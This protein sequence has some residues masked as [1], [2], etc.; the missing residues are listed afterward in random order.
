MNKPRPSLLYPLWLALALAILPALS[1]QEAPPAQPAPEKTSVE[2]PAPA[3]PGEKSPSPAVEQ[4][5]ATA[6]RDKAETTIEVEETAESEMRELT[7]ASPESGQKPAKSSKKSRRTRSVSVGSGGDRPPFGSHRVPAEATWHEAVSIM[8]STIVDG[9]VSSDAVAV[10]GSTTV[11]GSVGGSAIAVLGEVVVNGTVEGEVVAVLGD[12][13]LGPNAVIRGEI[14]CVLGQVVRSDGAQTLGGVNEIGDFG[15]F[16]GFE[17][18]RAWLFKCLAWGR[19]LAF[20]ENL[21]WAWMVAG[22][23]LVFYVLLALLFPR[24]IDRCVENLEQRPGGTFLAA[25]LAALLSPVLIVLLAITGIGVFL[26]PFVM[27]GLFLATL[28]GKAAILA[29]F[30]RRFTNRMSGGVASHAAVAVLLGGVVVSLLYCVWILGLILWAFF[31]VLGMG[32]VVY[33]LALSMKAARPAA[34]PPAPGATPAMAAAASAGF[35]ATPSAP[36][37]APSAPPSPVPPPA[38]AESAPPVVNIEG[39]Y[40]AAAAGS[41]A[42]AGATSVPGGTAFAPTA[43]FL[44][45]STLPRA[46]FWIRAA[47]SLLDFLLV[48]I[49]FGV[50]SVLDGPGPLF[51]GM[52][53][54]HAVMWKFKGTTIGGIICGLKVVRLDDRP[55]DWGVAIVRV[56]SAFLSFA[57]VCLGFIW[58]AFDD[59]KQSW[60]D[61]I[62]GTTIVKV[63]KGTPLL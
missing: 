26:I 24:G 55:V 48:G 43:P 54:Y 25:V 53:I 40:A 27:A 4:P 63:P 44:S 38:P 51:L 33:T 3:E 37:P 21:G 23:F 61:K 50:L 56:L 7:P 8:G 59:E 39:S 42:A 14:V 29:W 11:N 58:V 45:A 52:A 57:I 49:V 36:A 28:F 13:I 18:L 16:R 10:M 32:M 34:V 20:G 47:A 12:V 19:P 6:E 5:D 9:R 22:G 17:H 1:A 31:A 62:A 60:H 41:P 15:A 46:G 30:G 2:T 35:S